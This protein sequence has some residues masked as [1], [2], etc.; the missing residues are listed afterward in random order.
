MYL[1]KRDSSN[2]EVTEQSV[3]HVYGKEVVDQETQTV[4]TTYRLS[5]KVKTMILRNEV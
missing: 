1:I 2:G 5:A 3:S 4:L